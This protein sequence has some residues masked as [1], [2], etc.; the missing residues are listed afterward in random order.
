VAQLV[1]VLKEVHYLQSREYEN[2]P[3]RAVEL[4]SRRDEL[5]KYVI[6]LDLTVHFYNKIRQTVL[7]VEYPLIENQLNDIDEKLL[8]A[9]NSLTW[10][11]EGT[12]A[13]IALLYFAVSRPATLNRLHSIH[14]TSRTKHLFLF[15]VLVLVLTKSLESFKTFLLIFA[16]NISIVVLVINTNNHLIMFSSCT[17]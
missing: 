9:E 2:I 3:D 8:Q 11:S 5:R 12:A 6:N 15:L 13:F 16:I 14:V 4:Y 10:N 1:A 17:V 7:E